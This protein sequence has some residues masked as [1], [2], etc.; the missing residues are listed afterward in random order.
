M[1]RVAWCASNVVHQLQAN[2]LVPAALI[3]LKP[4]QHMLAASF[5]LMMEIG[6]VNPVG[7][8]CK[9]IQLEECVRNVDWVHHTQKSIVL[10]RK[11]PLENVR[12]ESANQRFDRSGCV[13]A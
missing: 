8:T 4:Y 13:P 1:R 6:D 9:V 3:V 11:Y 12:F 10:G 7:L 2:R 5:H